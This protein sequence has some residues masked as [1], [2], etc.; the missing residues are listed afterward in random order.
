MTRE[1]FLSSLPHLRE[2]LL[3]PDPALELAIENALH[4]NQW[5]IPEFTRHALHSIATAYLDESRCRAWIDSYLVEYGDPKQVGIIMAGNIPLVGFHDLFCV[6]A[7]GHQ[8]IVK[9]SD[10]DSLLIKEIVDQ[11]NQVLPGIRDQVQFTDRLAGYDAVIATGSN[12]AARYFEYY[13][14]KYPH[15]LRRNRNGVA[16]LT[17]EE[18]MED[19]KRLADDIFLYFG[20][21]CR[22]VSFMLV[23]DGY[24]FGMWDEAMSDYKS[25][26]H[27]NKYKNNLEYNFAIYIINQIPHI[28]LGH[29]ILKEDPA[30]ASRIGSLHFQYYTDENDISN[31]LEPRREEIQCLL[32]K[33]PVTNWEYVPFGSSQEP[34]LYQYA[35]GVDTM[36][37]LTAL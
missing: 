26:E 6:L 4:A 30:I 27:H 18:S 29:L 36:K 5:F 37:F 32:S 23:P 31:L 11:W 1:Q 35:D 9:L 34:S 19:L 24:H 20:L 33:D 7:S 17:G 15:I 16:I 10:K 28:Q 14:N 12:N 2:K 8:A 3:F 21:G 13:F 25:L 22:N